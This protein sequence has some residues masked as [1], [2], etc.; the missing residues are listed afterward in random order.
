MSIY[1]NGYQTEPVGREQ[2]TIKNP[3]NG[4]AVGTLYKA[5]KG[6]GRRIL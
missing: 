2:V 6:D 1:F 5:A 3:A 4:E